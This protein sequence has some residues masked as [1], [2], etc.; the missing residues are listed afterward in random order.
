VNHELLRMADTAT[1]DLTTESS[2]DELLAAMDTVKAL[3]EAV[4]VVAE[5]IEQAAIEWI[6]AN[7][8]IEERGV[9]YYVGPNRTTKC[10]DLAKTLE[11]VLQAT[12]GDFQA[13]VA[14]LSSS[15]WKHGACRDVLPVN[16]YAELFKTTEVADLKTGAAKPPRLQKVDD[17]FVKGTP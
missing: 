2:R 9:R 15:A 12:G 4:A 3:K 1:G 5:R 16:T 11:A 14:C 8:E 13:T 10:T 6:G 17:R 7:G